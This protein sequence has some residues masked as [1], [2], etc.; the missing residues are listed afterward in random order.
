MQIYPMNPQ[1]HEPES[2]KMGND[3]KILVQIKEHS[4]K[5][6]ARADLFTVDLNRH[7]VSSVLLLEELLVAFQ[8]SY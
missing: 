4:C 1:L 5:A 2:N 3:Q 7:K 8:S 6:K